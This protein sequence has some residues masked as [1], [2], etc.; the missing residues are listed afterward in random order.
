MSK[1]IT[2][3][4]L[5][6][7]L[8]FALGTVAAFADENGVYTDFSK[9]G[10]SKT[11]QVAD[12][13][14]IS[15]VKTFTFKFT[16]IGDQATP[17]TSTAA[18]TPAIADQSI[19]VGA[20]KNDEATGVLKFDAIFTDANAFPHAGLYVYDVVENA[21]VKDGLTC[22][23]T[24]YR[25]TVLVANKEGGGLEFAGVIVERY[26]Q[27]GTLEKV[28]P[29]IITNDNENQ[30]SGFDFINKYVEFVTDVAVTKEVKGAYADMGKAFTITVTV[31]IPST[32]DPADVVLAKDSKATQEGLTFTADLKNGESIAFAQIPAGS[33]IVVHENGYAGY[34]AVISGFVAKSGTQGQEITSDPS[35]VIVNG[36]DSHAVTVT[37][38]RDDLVPTGVIIDSLP[39]VLLIVVAL[40]GAVY[41]ALKKKAYNA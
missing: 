11:L 10:M 21:I 41:L 32:A 14:D 12:G 26:K 18:E 38:T 28:D 20:Q 33:K 17:A 6:L 39:Y 37:N 29:T 30:V 9:T 15:A 3:I 1:R 5:V 2:S 24:R 31:T 16:A 19:T 13:I 23:S 7:V 4:L 34:T 40:G 27:D 35:A 8:V 25:V 36:A 22:D